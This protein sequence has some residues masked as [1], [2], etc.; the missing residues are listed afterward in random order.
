MAISKKVTVESM[1]SM[2]I[3]GQLPLDYP[4]HIF[5][6]VDNSDLTVVRMHRRT[7]KCYDRSLIFTALN[8]CSLEMHHDNQVMANNTPWGQGAV[9]S[10]IH[11]VWY[12]KP[13]VRAQNIGSVLGNKIFGGETVDLPCHKYVAELPS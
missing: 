10:V 12:P 13:S 1:G 11:V 3:Y 9:V 4:L 2:T 6:T 7:G 5:E 8:R